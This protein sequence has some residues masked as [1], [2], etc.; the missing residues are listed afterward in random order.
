MST[1][2]TRTT[3]SS[4]DPPTQSLKVVDTFQHVYNWSHEHDVQKVTRERHGGD[5]YGLN[6]VLGWCDLSREVSTST[7]GVIIHVVSLMFCL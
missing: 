5:K 6:D 3:T 4:K 2:T 7:F 1:V